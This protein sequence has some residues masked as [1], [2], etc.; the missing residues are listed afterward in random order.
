MF[1]DEAGEEAV[2]IEVA[3]VGGIF[4]SVQLEIEESPCGVLI[5]AL[6]RFFSE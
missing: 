4:V 2:L 1:E 5:F 6:F 3:A